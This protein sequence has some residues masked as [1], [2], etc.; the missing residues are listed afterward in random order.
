[1][2]VLIHSPTM[3][4]SQS[5]FKAFRQIKITSHSPLNA[6]FSTITR[7]S[8]TGH[9]S[10]IWELDISKLLIWRTSFSCAPK[11]HLLHR[12]ILSVNGKVI[13]VFWISSR[14][15]QEYAEQHYLFWTWNN[16]PLILKC[17]YKGRKQINC[18]YTY[19][20]KY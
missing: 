9:F 13:I 4:I 19:L 20:L 3:K 7:T 14:K 5:T 2:A 11:F 6:W 15:W 1:M 16:S 12:H 17:P 10:I 18:I 8:Q